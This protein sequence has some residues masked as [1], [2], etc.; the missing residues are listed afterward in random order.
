MEK[1]ARVKMGL[2]INKTEDFYLYASDRM[3]QYMGN[4]MMVFASD[5]PH[6]TDLFSD[7]EIV[8]YDSTEELV[9]KIKYYAAHDDE[10]RKIAEKGY[11]RAHQIF[12]NQLIARYIVET[13]L[14]NP[15][16]SLYPFPHQIYR[17]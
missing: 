16:S 3:S 15:H 4:G 7:N 10:R 1:L 5:G 2:I 17:E 9:D 8:T 14:G 6:Y 11:L 13:T 12:N